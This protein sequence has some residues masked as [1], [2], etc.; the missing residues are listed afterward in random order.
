M[1][2]ILP[3]EKEHN[4]IPG[5]EKLLED[6]SQVWS[7]DTKECNKTNIDLSGKLKHIFEGRNW[8]YMK[9]ANI[10]Y[11][12][13]EYCTPEEVQKGEGRGYAWVSGYYMSRNI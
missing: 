7:E 1:D 4:N 5:Q 2:S 9:K 8:K 12:P 3:E 10:T 11:K 6:N 13:I